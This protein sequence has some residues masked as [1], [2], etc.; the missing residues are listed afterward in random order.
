[1]RTLVLLI[2]L[3]AAAPALAAGAALHVQVDGL[4]CPF[5]AYGLEKKLKPLP[6]VEGVRIDYKEGWVEL[7]VEEGADLDESAIRAAVRAAGFTPGAIHR[8]APGDDH[9]HAGGGGSGE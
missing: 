2:T 1:M 7:T 4:A 5:C 6:G 3:L 8:G 9:D